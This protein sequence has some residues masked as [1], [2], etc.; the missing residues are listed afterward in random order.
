MAKLIEK[1]HAVTQTSSGGMG[2]FARPQAP[3]RKAR[4]VAVFVAGGASDNNAL[5]T[6]LANGADGAIITG[7]RANA[8]APAGL[9][10]ALKAHDAIWGVELD[11]ESGGDALKAARDQGAA[12]AILGAQAPAG[13]LF[14]E[15]EKFDRVITLDPPR[16]DLALLT[17]RAVNLLPAQAALVRADFTPSGLAKLNVADFTRLQLLWESLRF[18]SLVTL[19]GMP[20]A[21]ALRLLVQLGADALVVSAAGAAAPSLG[22]QV[23]ALLTAL[24]GIPARREGGEG[25]AL[26]TGLF[27]PAS[28]TPGAVPGPTPSPR[29]QPEPAPD[30]DEE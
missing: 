4:P 6:A 16:D 25:G 8:T 2:F 28:G 12:F 17:L 1:L 5:N 9:D 11:A 20:D 10:G 18:P 22:D 21:A 3:A 29:P 27:G 14:E 13:A 7:W 24:E 23:K 15:L 30:P 26:L 19:A